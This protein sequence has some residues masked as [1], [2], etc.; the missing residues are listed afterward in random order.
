[1][2]PNSNSTSAGQAAGAPTVPL[3]LESEFFDETRGALL[4][5]DEQLRNHRKAITRPTSKIIPDK[6]DTMRLGIPKWN[7]SSSSLM[8]GAIVDGK[9]VGD[10]VVGCGEGVIVGR[11]VGA[12]DGNEVGGIVETVT[13]TSAQQSMSDTVCSEFTVM[14]ANVMLSAAAAEMNLVR[15][16][17]LDVRLKAWIKLVSTDAETSSESVFVVLNKRE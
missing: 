5:D 3:L 17:E 11:L 4:V 16:D 15:K 8:V 7:E 9:S 12:L 13:P 6:T 14:F 10:I 1:M 2:S